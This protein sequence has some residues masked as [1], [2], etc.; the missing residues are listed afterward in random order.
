VQFYVPAQAASTLH[1]GQ[2]V[3]LRCGGCEE[4]AG[5]I[6]YVSPIAEAPDDGS[7]ARLRFLVEARPGPSVALR[8][9]PGQAVEVML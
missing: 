3:R 5:R 9:R 6:V 7:M 1:H 2:R 8:L 4:I